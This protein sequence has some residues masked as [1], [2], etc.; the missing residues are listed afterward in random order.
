MLG[1]YP[2]V[3]IIIPAF[4]VEHYI[5]EA[6]ESALNQDYNN[7]EIIIV[8]DGS[9]DNTS[10]I[11]M[12]L[13]S[14]DN[15]IRLVNKK[16]GGAA[17]ARNLG[18]RESNGDFIMFLDGDDFYSPHAVSL[19]VSLIEKD[20]SDLVCFDFDTFNENG[21]LPRPLPNSFPSKL[22]SSGIDCVRFIYQGFLGYFSWAFLYRSSVLKGSGISYP[23]DIHVLEDAF[24]LNRFL[25]HVA[26]VSYL[27]ECIYHYRVIQNSLTRRISPVNAKTGIASIQHIMSL[28]KKDNLLASSH[29]H[30]VDLLLFMYDLNGNLHSK[31]AISNR[32]LIKKIIVSNFIDFSQLTVKQTFKVVLILTNTYYTFR[33]CINFIRRI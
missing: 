5:Q 12:R 29:K 10:K 22:S 25:R 31:L 33:L 17:S 19:A 4:N 13:S 28:A 27:N 3:S 9:T 18:I 8:N 11:C 14:K 23:E 21:I 32:N 1:N 6:V 20:K 7:I 16:N 15:R 2:L 24:F 30:F 26:N